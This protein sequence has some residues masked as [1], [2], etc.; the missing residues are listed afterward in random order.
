VT[1]ATTLS[2]QFERGYFVKNESVGNDA[3]SLEETNEQIKLAFGLALGAELDA[4]GF[5]SGPG[6]GAA[7]GKL[8]GLTR[9]QAKRVLNGVSSPSINR[10]WPLRSLGVSFDRILDKVNGTK[11]ITKTLYLNG[12][13]V[14][15]V[16]E[17][18]A[19]GNSC[20]AALIPHGTGYE[21][22]ALRQ[23]KKIPDNATPI[24]TVGFGAGDKLAIVKNDVKVRAALGMTKSNGSDTDPLFHVNNLLHTLTGNETYRAI[25][26]DWRLSDMKESDLTVRNRKHTTSPVLILTD[27]LM[28]GRFI[29]R[30]LG[31][32]DV[33]FVHIS[34]FMG[35]LADFVSSSINMEE[36]TKRMK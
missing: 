21:L 7:L 25:L 13:P 20:G 27:D 28:I 10:L 32:C 18:G 36:F 24:R 11:P 19:L 5:I 1:N 33:Q 6:R 31:N 9:S 4:V 22:I 30:A 35:H 14:P 12:T 26:M 8:L 29:A 3:G 23:G 17:L 34:K 15:A 16:V 2:D